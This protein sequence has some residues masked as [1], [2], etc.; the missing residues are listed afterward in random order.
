MSRPEIVVPRRKA[1]FGLYLTPA[2]LCI[3]ISS[4]LKKSSCFSGAAQAA[5]FPDRTPSHRTA[6]AATFLKGYLHDESHSPSGASYRWNGISKRSHVARAARNAGQRRNRTTR[7]LPGIANTSVAR[8][9]RVFQRTASDHGV[10]RGMAGSRW[11]QQS[12]LPT[13]AIGCRFGDDHTWTTTTR[14]AYAA[15]S[16][17]IPTYAARAPARH[18]GCDRGSQGSRDRAARVEVHRARKGLGLRDRRTPVRR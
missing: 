6:C 16:S 17:G 8:P 11:R 15:E 9:N 7:L 1:C 18:Q 13:G 4:L 10:C 12:R 3:T 2:N 5:R 14:Q